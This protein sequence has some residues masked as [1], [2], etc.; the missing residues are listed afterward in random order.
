MLGVWL[1][2]HF[3]VGN[4]VMNYIEDDELNTNL[5]ILCFE[6]FSNN[7]RVFDTLS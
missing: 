7:I 1:G 3:R 4:L 2:L 6:Q 5:S